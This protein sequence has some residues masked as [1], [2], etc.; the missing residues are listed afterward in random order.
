[1]TLADDW[2]AWCEAEH[3]PANTVARR[4]AVLRSFPDAGTADRERVEAWWAT[5][6]GRSAA[7]RANDL[8]CLRAFYRWLIRWEHR[9]EDPTIRLDAPKL[10]KGLPRPIS[11][12]DLWKLLTVL[13][14]DLRRA[15]C[16][17][18]YGG[19]RVSEAAELTWLE[20]DLENKRVRV[21]GKGEATRLVGL[22]PLLL[23]SIL[24]DTGGNVVAAGGKPYTAGTLQRKVNRAI[25]AAD[26]DATFH[27]L[28]HRF[29]TVA[30]G[31]TG[32]IMAVSRAMGH[33]SPATT[34]IYAATS[35]KMLDVIAEA[36]AR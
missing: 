21:Q 19:L 8:A 22:S 10:P 13:P 27:Q 1:M 5:R 31:A 35:D 7:T 20:V 12:A 23:D 28:R 32:D 11:R 18:A 17:G 6:R 16:L 34:A 29:G 36:V 2:L 9:D 26:V 4:R 33:A 15:V 30:L 14:D 3:I 24:P 25:R